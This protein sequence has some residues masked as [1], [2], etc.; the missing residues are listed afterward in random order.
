MVD[1]RSFCHPAIAFNRKVARIGYPRPLAC[2]YG[3][4]IEVLLAGL[5]VTNLPRHYLMYRVHGKSL[6][7]SADAEVFA[8]LRTAVCEMRADYL[9]RLLGLGAEAVAYSDCM[10]RKI[11]RRDTPED[12]AA[13]DRL[14]KIVRDRLGV[15]V[16]FRRV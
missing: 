2:D 1:Q 3:L 4:L 6:S 10:E 5:D 14:G 12:L 11:F 8:R 13:L 9:A 7:N 16:D 15:G